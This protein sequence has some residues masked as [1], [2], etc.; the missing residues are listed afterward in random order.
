MYYETNTIDKDS[1]TVNIYTPSSVQV[2][3]IHRYIDLIRIMSATNISKLIARCELES[4]DNTCVAG[5]STLIVETTGQKVY[6]YG[7]HEAL[8]PMANIDIGTAATIWDCPTTGISYMFI[9][10]E[11]LCFGDKIADTLIIPQ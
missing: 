8:V 7:F 10:S 9:I 2:K 4:H 11:A 5:A 3:P 1:I 6:V